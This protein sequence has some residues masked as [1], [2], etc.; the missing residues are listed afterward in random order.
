MKEFILDNWELILTALGFVSVNATKMYA[1]I[2]A[3][4][5]GY[6]KITD[7]N[8]PG[9]VKITETEQA[10]FNPLMQKVCQLYEL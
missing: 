1:E 6:L 2:V 5:N 9:G 4:K 7:P 10:F 8:S 3:V